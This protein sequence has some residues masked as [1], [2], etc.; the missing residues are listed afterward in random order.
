ME[1]W[2]IHKFCETATLEQLQETEKKLKELAQRQASA[3]VDKALAIVTEYLELK[4]LF[5]DG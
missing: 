3:N 1:L 5:D 2:K 4:R